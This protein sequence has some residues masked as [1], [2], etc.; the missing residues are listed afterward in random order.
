MTE[1]N[2]PKLGPIII[3]TSNIQKAKEFYINVFGFEI[4]NESPHYV[5]ARAIDGAHIEIE[6]DSENRF[7]KWKDNNVGT[8]KNSEFMVNDIFK[9]FKAVEN[10]GG[11]VVSQP[12]ERPWGGY[13]GEIADPEGNIFLISQK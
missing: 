12:V 8:Y 9:F 6:E 2:F 1:N 7:P 11:R 10:G 13:G 3:G 4:E 5:S